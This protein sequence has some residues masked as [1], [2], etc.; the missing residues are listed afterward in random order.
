MGATTLVALTVVIFINAGSIE[1]TP[2]NNTEKQSPAA[3]DYRVYALPIREGVQFAGEHVPLNDPEIRE[4]YDREILSNTYFQSQGL[5]Y[6]KRANRYFP[7]IEPIL[8]Q[9]NIPD[10]FKYLALIESGLMNVVSPA[11]AAGFWQFMKTTGP[12]YGL[13]VNN[14]VDERYHLEKATHAACKYLK[15]AYKK[16]GSWALAAAA[17]NAGP[18]RIEKSLSEQ[19]VS[20]Y[21]DLYLNQETAR[22]VFRIMA[23][24][25]IIENPIE[26]GFHFD[27]ED[28]YST[29]NTYN[30]QVDK[31][32]PSLVDFAIDHGV[33]YK[34]LKHYNPWLRS[35]TLP[36]VGDKQYT[37]TL[38]KKD[39]HFVMSDIFENETDTDVVIPSENMD[40]NE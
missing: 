9:H 25:E 12:Q 29:N 38:P 31:T 39:V 34:L 15:D 40:T 35:T 20:N 19:R 28:L 13:E 1:D 7:T 23:V 21:F 22:Y 26:Y 3:K 17:Y 4:R 14:Y 10:D 32:I 33:T 36:I 18:A 8:K 6:F 2:N 24:K 27:E 16:F 30:I 11:G 37:I 5:L